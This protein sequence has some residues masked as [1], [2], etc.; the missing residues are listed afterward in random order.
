MAMRP[1][2][3]PLLLSMS[4]IALVGAVFWAFWGLPIAM[5]FV[6]LMGFALAG[7]KSKRS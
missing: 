7:S 1:P 4:A 6:A 5:L 2:D 3:P